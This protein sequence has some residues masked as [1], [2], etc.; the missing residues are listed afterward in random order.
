MAASESNPPRPAAPRGQVACEVESL[1]D[2]HLLTEVRTADGQNRG[3]DH[4]PADVR[5]RT[6]RFCRVIGGRARTGGRAGR[7]GTAGG[8]TEL[9]IVCEELAAAGTPLLLLVV[10]PAIVGTIIARHGTPAQRETYLPRL[11]DG[12]LTIGFAI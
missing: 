1:L 9:A 5:Y 11:A 10:S 2:D 6:I 12:S 8:I 7:G 3:Q 4:I